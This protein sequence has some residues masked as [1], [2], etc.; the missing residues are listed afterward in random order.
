MIDP[1]ALPDLSPVHDALADVE[2][3]LH[4]ATQDLPCLAEVGMRP[5]RLFD[6]EP[7]RPPGRA[8]P[9]RPRRRR[10]AACSG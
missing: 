8:A 9:R 10:R 5:S 2:W 3:V 1:A 7:R 4:A 6:T